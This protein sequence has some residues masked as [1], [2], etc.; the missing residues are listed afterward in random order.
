MKWVFFGTSNFAA[1]ILEKFIQNNFLPSLVVTN[2]DKPAGR[3]KILFS[4]PVKV[5]ATQNKLKIW[6]PENLSLENPKEDKYNFGI[7]ASYGK[8]I[9]PKI[10]N[11]FSLGI[12]VVHPSL[13]PKYRGPTPIQSFILSGEKET[14]VTLF[15]MDEKIDH[16]PILIQ[17]KISN[18]EENLEE[19]TY[20]ALHN[21]LAEI[22]ANLVLEIIPKFLTQQIIPVPQ[23]EKI[24]T[25]TKK[26]TLE[27]A[28][29]KEEDLKKAIENGG[30][31]AIN[32]DRKIRALNPEPGVWTIKNGKRIKLLKAKIINKKLK[33]IQIQKEGRKPEFNSQI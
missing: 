2:P 20:Q 10:I 17:K 23:N 30:N 1:I 24:A 18:N 28:F 5:I 3:K 15:L 11:L 4:S 8:I 33:L 9:P 25:Y 7:L 26:F 21:K 27:D 29:I 19:I 6:Q 14:G 13:L 32:I 31:E 22:S 16:G 12:I